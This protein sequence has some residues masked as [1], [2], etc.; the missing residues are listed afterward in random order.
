MAPMG[1]DQHMENVKMVNVYDALCLAVLRSQ[2]LNDSVKVRWAASYSHDE[3]PSLRDNCRRT[4][5]Q[6][7]FGTQ[8]TV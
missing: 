3:H 5:Q 1:A 7:D 8:S 2:L 4:S 6:S